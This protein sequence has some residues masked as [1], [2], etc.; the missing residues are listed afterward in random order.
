MS[1]LA[2]SLRDLHAEWGSE[3]AYHEAYLDGKLSTDDVNLLLTHVN[4]NNFAR[5]LLAYSNDRLAKALERFG[6]LE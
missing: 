4:R 2:R 3:R 1:D 6:M 5:L